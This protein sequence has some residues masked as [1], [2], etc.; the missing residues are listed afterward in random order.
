MTTVCLE[1]G[2]PD[3]NP[4]MTYKM[5]PLEEFTDNSQVHLLCEALG[6]DS[7]TQN[8]AQAIAWHFDG[9]LVVGKVGRKKP[10]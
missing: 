1:H 7:L 9:W 6:R 8:T 3:P 2:K 4:K 5:I 10:R